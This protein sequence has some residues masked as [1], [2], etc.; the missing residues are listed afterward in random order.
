MKLPSKH[1]DQL[2]QTF[3]VDLEDRARTD[4]KRVPSIIST[5]LAYLD[6]RKYIVCPLL[7]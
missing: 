5:M 1:A 7:I 2:D 4:N 3:G 6:N